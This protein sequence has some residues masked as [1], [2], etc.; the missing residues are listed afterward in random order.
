MSKQLIWGLIQPPS[1]VLVVVL[2][3]GREKMNEW[4]EK[5]NEWHQWG[6]LDTDLVPSI[7]R[8]IS[9][10]II[11]KLAKMLSWKPEAKWPKNNQPCLSLK[12]N[13]ITSLIIA[14]ALKFMMDSC[15]PSHA[16]CCCHNNHFHDEFLRLFSSTRTSIRDCWT[17]QYG[18]SEF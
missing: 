18:R 11:F 17:V 15:S 4:G 9:R 8:F 2:S 3:L 5:W 14:A 12:S 13:Q 1:S 16:S 7:A 6:L 10:I